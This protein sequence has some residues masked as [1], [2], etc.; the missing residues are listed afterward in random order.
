MYEA[1]VSR[2]KKALVVYLIDQSGS[3]AEAWT[4]GDSKA[5]EV[6]K[7]L[8][9]NINSM[10]LECKKGG[11]VRDYFDI[12]AIGYG[13]DVGSTLHGT[14]RGH[15]TVSTTELYDTPLSN[16]GEAA[17]YIEASSSRGGTDMATA[18][19]EA[20]AICSE[21]SAAHQS[22]FPPTVLHITDGEYTG[23]NPTTAANELKAVSTTDG[24]T[25][26][27]NIHISSSGGSPIV[28]PTSGDALSGKAKELFDISSAIPTGSRHFKSIPV[29]SKAFAY[30]AN[31]KDL[32]KC[33]EVGTVLL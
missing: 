25:L 2:A 21:W 1:E 9:E 29:N 11:E 26:L 3:M 19:R 15:R 28:M 4:N 31:L 16:S 30:N 23:E 14:L 22:S 8:N 17:T 32:S 24:A 12:A 27:W 10:I 20:A 33:I 18:F 6:A 5:T 7:L 13:S